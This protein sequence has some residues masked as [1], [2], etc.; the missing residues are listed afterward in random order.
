MGVRAR[1]P[2]SNNSYSECLLIS[3]PP[4]DSLFTHFSK[5]VFE[6]LP[7]K[8]QATTEQRVRS[9]AR[10]LNSVESLN[11]QQVIVSHSLCKM[12]FT[13]ESLSVK[14][15]DTIFEGIPDTNCGNIVMS[16]PLKG[17]IQ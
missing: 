4:T 1:R 12:Q 13:L 5:F 9:T 17:A 14:S 7:D 3:N 15:F 11:H 2:R 10:Y 6:I 16:L 8:D